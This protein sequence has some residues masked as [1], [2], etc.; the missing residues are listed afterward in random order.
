[1]DSRQIIDYL[2]ENYGDEIYLSL[3]NQY[4]PSGSLE[5]Y[6]ELKKRV[7]RQVYERLIQYTIRKGVEN[8]FIQE[9]DTAKESFIP[10]F[11]GEG[12]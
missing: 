12:V 1:M 7:K 11:D 9:G 5:K 2:Y 4:T 8:A 10:D 6:P 3:M